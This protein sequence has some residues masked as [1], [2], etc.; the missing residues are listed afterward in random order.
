[1]CL[2]FTLRGKLRSWTDKNSRASFENSLQLFALAE[3]RQIF[4]LSNL[5]EYLWTV[6]ESKAYIYKL[7]T[8]DG[9]HTFLSKKHCIH[10]TCPSNTL[11]N[12]SKSFYHFFVLFVKAFLN[13]E[14]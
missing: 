4:I 11:A 7:F 1:M 10:K 2:C 5:K 3:S 6:Q 9:P 14:R 13:R 12:L 8:A